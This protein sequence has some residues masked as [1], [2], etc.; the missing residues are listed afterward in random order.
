MQQW[1]YILPIDQHSTVL[2]TGATGFVGRSLVHQLRAL[3]C[4]IKV[5]AREGSVADTLA[6][7]Y[8][9]ELIHGN[10]LS[11]AAV[12]SACE[13]VTHVFH[14]AGRGQSTANTR[15]NAATHRVNVEGT[16]LLAQAAANAPGL[17]RFIHLSTIAVHGDTNNSPADETTEFSA[18][19][20]Y[21]RTKLEAELW[22]KNF[23][24]D[25]KLPLTVLRP[26]AIV[27]PGDQRLLKLFKLANRRYIPLP[28]SG[29]NRYQIIHIDDCIAVMIAAAQAEAA[30]GETYVCGNSETLTLREILRLI[31]LD[32]H[33]RDALLVSLPVKP[34]K[35]VLGAVEKLCSTF[36]WRTPLPATRLAF[37]EQNHWFDTHKMLGDLD[38]VLCHDNE[39]ALRTTR[40]W[41]VENEWL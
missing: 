18:K 11:K 28:G 24:D 8:Q 15:S 7:N 26:C 16:K 22:L 39:S 17:E 20:S 32:A 10:I 41:Y 33:G 36:G 21:E 6:N 31:R 30:V 3:N 13:D 9:A 19:S 38:V 12:Q 34:A 25:R 23:A 27:G 5:L 35:A 4:H 14:L 2:V 1:T 29:H 40:D 37:F